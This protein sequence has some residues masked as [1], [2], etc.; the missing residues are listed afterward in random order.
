ML[1][2]YGCCNE[3]STHLVWSSGHR[4]SAALLT[5]ARNLGVGGVL[6]PLRVPGK[7]LDPLLEALGDPWIWPH[8]SGLCLCGHTASS[9]SLCQVSSEWCLFSNL[10]P[11]PPSPQIIQ[12]GP[13]ISRSLTERGLKTP[14]FQIRSGSQVPREECE[15]TFCGPLIH[16]LQGGMWL[17]LIK[18]QNTK[19]KTPKT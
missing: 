12:D 9:S 17:V 7:T 19:Q 2:S 16:L 10:D 6:L 8:H 14:P 5:K 4:S 1:A 3:L 15:H 11:L 18:K 13:F